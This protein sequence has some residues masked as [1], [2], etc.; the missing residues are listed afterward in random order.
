M[1]RWSCVESS[2][3]EDGWCPSLWHHPPASLC[4]FVSS[5]QAHRE[6]QRLGK[7]GCL[8]V[9]VHFSSL[10]HRCEVFA[11]RRHQLLVVCPVKATIYSLDGCVVSCKSCVARVKSWRAEIVAVSK[12]LIDVFIRVA[13][14]FVFFIYCLHRVH[15]LLLSFQILS[16]FLV[17]VLW[18]GGVWDFA[19]RRA[20]LLGDSSSAVPC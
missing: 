8:C 5:S 20:A 1:C 14:L 6:F 16:S 13:G 4:C 7:S 2:R 11:K 19:I 9:D 12:T 15:R 10:F 18:V 3:L 17:V